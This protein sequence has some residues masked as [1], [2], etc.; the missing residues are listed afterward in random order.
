[1]GIELSCLLPIA[2]I[3]GCHHGYFVCVF[4]DECARFPHAGLDYILRVLLLQRVRFYWLESWLLKGL[5]D[6][7]ALDIILV[8]IDLFCLFLF[9][10]DSLSVSSTCSQT[11]FQGLLLEDPVVLEIE[12]ELFL[13]KQ[14][15][16]HWDDLLVVGPFLELQLPR[17]IQKLLELLW[18]TCREI[19]YTCHC[20]LYLDL[21]V[22]FFFGFGWES[23]PGKCP[24]KE[25][26]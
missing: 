22:F 10:F 18:V 1:M 2:S 15:S 26:H 13:H 20:F 14:L 24:F 12:V 11:L 16:K 25:V 5:Q 3:F 8:V 19:F 9:L 21:L 4:V 6:V 7:A 23:L 17:V